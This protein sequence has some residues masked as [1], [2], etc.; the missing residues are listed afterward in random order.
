MIFYAA[1][2]IPTNKNNPR[3]QILV[4]AGFLTE[5]AEE[6]TAAV[7]KH[8]LVQTL[9]HKM[10]HFLVYAGSRVRHAESSTPP[11]FTVEGFNDLA[12][13]REYGEWKMF[14]G[15][16]HPLL[17]PDSE[18][19]SSRGLALAT[20]GSQETIWKKI[21]D[22]ALRKRSNLPIGDA[23]EGDELSDLLEVVVEELR[24]LYR[25]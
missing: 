4:N 12:E 11:E 14:G 15:V 7:A 6:S 1:F 3:I 5:I 25:P 17:K 10:A 13:G 8:L 2:V 18:L 9:C 16:I 23:F 19:C 22:E 20:T 21:K 24:K